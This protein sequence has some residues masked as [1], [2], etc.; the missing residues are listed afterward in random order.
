MYV[1]LCCDIVRYVTLRNVTTVFPLT[2]SLSLYYH[3]TY[4]CTHDTSGEQQEI[5]YQLMGYGIPTQVLPTTESGQ[6]KTKNYTQ[7]YKTRVMLEKQAALAASRSSFSGDPSSTSS[8]RK[9]DPLVPGACYGAIECPRLNDVLYERTKPCMFHPG[10][11]LFKG[12]L[13]ER[14]TDHATLT[15][16]AKRDLTWSIVEEVERRRGRFLKWDQRG[17]WVPIAN[18]SEIRLKV[19]TSLRDFNKHTRALNK[20][21]TISSVSCVAFDNKTQ[22]YKH[23]IKKRRVMISYD[24]LSISNSNKCGCYNSIRGCSL[25]RE[26]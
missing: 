12:L 2:H 21:E 24:E 10:N 4:K 14:K 13:E 3:C 11:T 18:R 6:I 26:D 16:T 15:Q 17:F 7:W 22:D 5:Q 8:N 20:C 23:D 19:A 25:R 9:S 1:R